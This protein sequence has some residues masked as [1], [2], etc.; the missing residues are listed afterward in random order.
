[1]SKK[2]I[3]AFKSVHAPDEEVVFLREQVQELETKLSRQRAATG[4][5]DWTRWYL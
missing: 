2:D 3:S 1:M 4:E 5:F